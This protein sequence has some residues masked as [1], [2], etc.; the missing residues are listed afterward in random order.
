MI[1]ISN[2]SVLHTICNGA[3]NLFKNLFSG[4]GRCVN[5]LTDI[6]YLSCAQN[7]P[8]LL[9]VGSKDHVL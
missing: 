6:H 2:T 1:K 5:D 9:E 7:T 4:Q 8:C 3:L